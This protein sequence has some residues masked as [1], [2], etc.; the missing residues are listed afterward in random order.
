MCFCNCFRRM[1]CPRFS[2]VSIFIH[3]TQLSCIICAETFIRS[4][5]SLIFDV[6][7]WRWR[8]AAN[9]CR[10]RRRR[11]CRE[12]MMDAHGWSGPNVAFN[13]FLDGHNDVTLGRP[14][15]RM[16]HRTTHQRCV[17]LSEVAS[18]RKLFH[19]GASATRVFDAVFEK[20]PA[21]GRLLLLHGDYVWLFCDH[22]H[23]KSWDGVW[24]LLW[25]V[26]KVNGKMFYWARTI[27]ENR[28][29]WYVHRVVH[30]SR[31]PR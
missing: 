6:R 27:G 22:W 29:L 4:S 31:L 18:W 5:A 9:E 28:E 16:C 19:F 10:R 13:S 14:Y 3:S 30:C 25:N 21:N 8:D 20:V 1:A 7:P 17:E 24:V 2:N 11:R 15:T 12:G 23:S 26:V